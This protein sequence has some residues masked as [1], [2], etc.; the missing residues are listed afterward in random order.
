MPRK[1]KQT[2]ALVKWDQELAKYAEAAAEQEANAGG[3]NFFSLR[4]GQLTLND[5]PLPN[6]E[7]GVVIVDSILE[8]TYYEGGYNPDNSQGPKCYGFGRDEETIKPHDNVKEPNA[9][10]C[11]D[12]EFNQWGSAE[13]GRGKACKNRRRLAVVAGGVISKSG[14]FTPHKEPAIY[15]KSPVAF[16]ALPVT[17]VNAYAAY[18]KQLAIMLKRPPWAVFTRIALESD[19]KT[20][21]KVTFEC[22]DTVPDA[23]LGAIKARHD[24]VAATIDF[25]YAA[26]EAKKPAKRKKQK[27]RKF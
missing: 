17:S 15:T 11:K 3:G 19:A 13:V 2:T 22:L 25:P 23:L 10:R 26:F 20:L 24:E 12:C 18:V 6:N 8:N 5:N 27:R 16:L 7:M 1:R 9:D 14:D 21:F 4:G